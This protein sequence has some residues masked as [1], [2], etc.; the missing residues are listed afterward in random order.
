MS[1]RFSILDSR[2]DRRRQAGASLIELVA[3]LGVLTIGLLG[4]VSVFYYG[5]DK[6]KAVDEGRTAVSMARNEIEYLRSRPFEGLADAQDAPFHDDA[7]LN[8][9]PNARGTVS[10]SGYPGREDRLKQVTATVA[11]TGENGRTIRKSLTTLMAG[12]GA[13]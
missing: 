13:P 5:M 10:I 12:R 9:L 2:F 11:W 8:G 6:L 3:A 4:G 7:A 1:F